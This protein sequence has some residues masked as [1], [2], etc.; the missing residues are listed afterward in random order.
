MNGNPAVKPVTSHF[1]DF[2]VH[3]LA[4]YCDRRTEFDILLYS[5]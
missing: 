1:I 3:N 2:W 4:S 5:F